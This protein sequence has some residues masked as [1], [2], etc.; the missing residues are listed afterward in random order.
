MFCKQ[1]GFWVLA[2]TFL[3]TSSAGADKP[4]ATSGNSA[5]VPVPT[6]RKM[7]VE[8]PDDLMKQEANAPASRQIS[9]AGSPLDTA[10]P[11]P[12]MAGNSK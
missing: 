12:A 10:A 3:C 8:R 4:A 2:C 6:V 1:I 9:S 11:T 5:T 7:E